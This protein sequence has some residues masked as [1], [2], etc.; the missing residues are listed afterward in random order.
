MILEGGLAVTPYRLS[1]MGLKGVELSGK[2]G[3]V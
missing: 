3:L 2:K 1:A